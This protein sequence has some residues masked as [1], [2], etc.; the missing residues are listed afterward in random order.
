MIA[1]GC[2]DAP[3]ST[4]S[5]TAAPTTTAEV[6]VGQ[7]TECLAGYVTNEELTPL[8]QATVGLVEANASVTTGVDGA[9][10]FCGLEP[11][12]YTLQVGRLGYETLVRAVEVPYGPSRLHVPLKALPV[13][14]PYS[15]TIPK[16][17]HYTVGM[18]TIDT[19]TNRNVAGTP[20][21][22]PC[23]WSATAPTIPDHFV[24]EAKWTR[25][26]PPP[27]GPDTMYYILRSGPAFEKGTDIGSFGSIPQPW[28]VDYPQEKLLSNANV[29]AAAAK[30]E[31]PLAGSMFCT[32]SAA[33]GIWPCVDQ[34]IDMWLSFLYDYSEDDV[35]NFTALPKQ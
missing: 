26:I 4:A 34:R 28:R 33:A 29:K 2:T 23:T 30:G 13:D 14:E 35:G 21:C 24:W 17:V 27:A 11:G 32:G 20:T 18:S 16:S 7:G 5:T 12:K 1:S 6:D 31:V 22:N 15:L 9:F 8:D 25:T 3:G 10:E 19:T